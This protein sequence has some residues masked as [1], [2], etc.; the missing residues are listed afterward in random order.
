MSD[1]ELRWRGGTIGDRLWILAIILIVWGVVFPAM[2]I[3]AV[4]FLGSAFEAVVEHSNMIER[5]KK[6][7]ITPYEY[8][9]CNRGEK[10]YAQ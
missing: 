10:P 7:A 6:K 1:R 2:L 4:L 5:C 8:H 3:A 9:R